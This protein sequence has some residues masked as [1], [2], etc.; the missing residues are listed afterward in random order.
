MG[1]R[2][3]ILEHAVI[4]LAKKGITAETVPK[5]VFQTVR[6]VDTQT[7][8]VLASLVGWAPTVP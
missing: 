6:R 7:G 5:F 1:V 4:I 3:G 8:C 2:M